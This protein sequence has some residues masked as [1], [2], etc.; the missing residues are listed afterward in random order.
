MSV[1]RQKSYPRD[2]ADGFDGTSANTRPATEGTE[3]TGIAWIHVVL[4][5]WCGYGGI[6]T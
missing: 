6:A 2:D 3:Q 1:V 5:T 4:C